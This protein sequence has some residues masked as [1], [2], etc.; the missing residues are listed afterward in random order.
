MASGDPTS[1]GAILWTRVVPTV[2]QGVSATNFDPKMI[3]WISPSHLIW[4]AYSAGDIRSRSGANK[5]LL[6][7]C[8][9]PEGKASMEV[10]VHAQ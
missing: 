9:V 4:S 7:Q 1:T 8:E 2:A 6:Y 10:L 3:Q 5:R